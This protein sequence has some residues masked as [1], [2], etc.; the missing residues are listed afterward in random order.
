MSVQCH[1]ENIDNMARCFTK[2]S[3]GYYKKFEKDKINFFSITAILEMETS[4]DK[5][6]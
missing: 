1:N 3:S 2:V 4:F 6:F 5:Q